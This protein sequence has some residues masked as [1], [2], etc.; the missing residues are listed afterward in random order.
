MSWTRKFDAPIALKDG[1][2][3]VSLDDARRLMLSLPEPNLRAYHWQSTADLLLKAACHDGRFTLARALAQLPRALEAEGLI[4]ARAATVDRSGP[5]S[6][7]PHAAAT[8][9]MPPQKR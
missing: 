6:R 1:R 3:L 9:K 8:S 4:S 5:L 2:K 7:A